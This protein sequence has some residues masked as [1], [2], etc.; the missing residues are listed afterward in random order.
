MILVRESVFELV[1]G[2]DSVA[3]RVGRLGI[4]QILTLF[5]VNKIAV[6]CDAGTL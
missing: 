2:A 3:H 6:T 4:I 1:V 5:P